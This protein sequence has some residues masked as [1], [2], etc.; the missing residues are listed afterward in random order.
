MAAAVPVGVHPYRPVLGDNHPVRPSTG[1]TANERPE[2]V[3]VLNPVKHDNQPAFAGHTPAFHDLRH[4]RVGKCLYPERHSLV[5][6]G[7]AKT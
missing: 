2:V 3:G 4:I 7:T 1:S 5:V 6:F